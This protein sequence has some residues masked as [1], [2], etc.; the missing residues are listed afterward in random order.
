MTE[1]NYEHI[2]FSVFIDGQFQWTPKAYRVHHDGLEKVIDLVVHRNL[3]DN[4]NWH[5][6]E[7]KSGL[8]VRGWGSTRDEAVFV[9]LRFLKGISTVKIQQAIDEKMI[10]FESDGITPLHIKPNLVSEPL[11]T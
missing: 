3:N 4:R 1:F 11:E 6:S 10:T 9:A 5:V 2:P 7:Y 8:S